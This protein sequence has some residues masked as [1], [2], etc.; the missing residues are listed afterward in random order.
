MELLTLQKKD[1]FKLD[2]EFATEIKQ[3]FEHSVENL[4]E[5]KKLVGKA[6]K[7]YNIAK[8]EG[9][10]EIKEEEFEESE[11]E[12]EEPRNNAPRVKVAASKR[13]LKT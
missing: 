6:E 2:S 10:E 1:L 12:L 7:W 5:L 3:L 11:E 4:E 9:N 13:K 8:S